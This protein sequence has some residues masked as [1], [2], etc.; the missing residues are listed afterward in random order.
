MV[1]GILKLKRGASFLNQGS[2]E[3]ASKSETEEPSRLYSKQELNIKSL[4][5]QIADKQLEILEIKKKIS[6]LSK[7][8]LES[9]EDEKIALNQQQER[10]TNSAHS[11]N[12][13]K[14]T[15]ELT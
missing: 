15:S 13:P 12:I 5:K 2:L 14:S 7:E 8:D 3:E 4:T 11:Q 10:A 1:S 6:V 9:P